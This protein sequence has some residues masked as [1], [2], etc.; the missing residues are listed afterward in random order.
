MK[1]NTTAF[2]RMVSYL[3]DNYGMS[4]EGAEKLV[5][6][7]SETIYTT[8]EQIRYKNAIEKLS[9]SKNPEEARVEACKSIINSSSTWD[10]ITDEAHRYQLAGSSL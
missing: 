3:V 2:G 10:M 9:G 4:Q 6:T 7:S 1:E 8:R 5:V